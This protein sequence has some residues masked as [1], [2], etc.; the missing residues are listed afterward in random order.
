MSLVWQSATF[1]AVCVPEAP[2]RLCL[3]GDTDSHVASLLG[4]IYKKRSRAVA[5]ATALFISNLLLEKS[6]VVAVIIQIPSPPKL[7]PSFCVA[8]RVELHQL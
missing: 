5:D 8:L 7:H 3:A 6:V 2:A 1:V 4:M